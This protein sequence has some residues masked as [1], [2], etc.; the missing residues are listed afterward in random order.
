MQ[1]VASHVLQLLSSGENLSSIAG[2]DFLYFLR[3]EIPT[4]VVVLGSLET[5]SISVIVRC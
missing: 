1:A 2:N 5:V 3:T 4:P